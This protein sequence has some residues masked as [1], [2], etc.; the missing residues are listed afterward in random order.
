MR[1]LVVLLLLLCL[2][3]SLGSA[4]DTVRV[5]LVHGSFGNFRHRDDYDA[6]LKSLGWTLDKFENKDFGKLAA[7]LGNYDLV[8][9]T[10]LFNYSQNVTDFSLYREQLLS[11]VQRG[12]AVVLTDCN[13]PDHV[14]WLAKLGPDWAVGVNN[15]AT[16]GTPNK[17]FDRTHPLFSAVAPVGGLGGTWMH[18]E[19]AA[20]WQVLAR[21]DDDGA[22]ALLR[23]YGRG[24]VLL[25]SFWGYDPG[26]LRNI[27]ATLQYTRAG[28]LP[29]LPALTA[30]RLGD[31]A[32]A[33][34]FRNVTDQ[35]L[36]VQATATAT[37][38][39]GALRPVVSEATAAAGAE[40][41][42]PLT[43]PLPARGTYQVRLALGVKGGPE[44]P[45]AAAELTIPPLMAF[46]VLEPRYRGV[47][48]A[49]A[50]PRRVKAEVTLHPYAEKLEGL[51]W[52]ARLLRGTTL[53]GATAGGP[54]RLEPASGVG[55]VEFSLPYK[56]GQGDCVLELALAQKAGGKALYTARH[57]IAVV[58]E[59][60]AQ[61]FLDD[62]L[63]LRRDG[64][65]FFPI[66]VY[67]V[68]LKDFAQ[69]KA[70]GFNTIQA[71]GTK[72]AQ[73]RENLDAAQQAGLQVILEGV[74]YAANTGNLEAMLPVLKSFEKHPA[75]LSWYLTDEPSGAEKL[76][77]C[78]RVYKYLQ[79]VD[80]HH[81]VFMTSCSPTEFK[82]YAPVT[83][84]FAVDPYPIPSG[85]VTTVS[86]WM[87]MAREAT[88]GERP[89][90]LIPQLLNWAAYDGHPEKGRYPT[91][92][93]ER[94]MVYQGLVWGAKAIFYYPWD[95]GSTGLVK[96]A[97]LREA[98]GRINAELAE[99]GPRLLQC[100]YRLLARNE[101]EHKGLYAAAY[102]GEAETYIIAVN[103]GNQQAAL[104]VP[105]PEAPGAG[106]TVL[107]EGGRQVAVTAGAI[108][109][110]FAP[111]A[112]HVY[113]LAN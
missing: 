109:D 4:A 38:P 87:E 23:S 62:D 50:P 63:N 107:F 40:G 54:L 101:G 60:S 22:T 14:N 94:N 51:L 26:Q 61:V 35:P 85:P 32:L 102:R 78:D 83:D 27:V 68:P 77:W 45:A 33:V 75:L 110:T 73:A 7:Q 47:V 67:H 15:C 44:F 2:L 104:T 5:A 112:V 21:C 84:I 93:E 48:M 90:W 79:A 111:L 1:R 8:L 64:K 53:L 30:L 39:A 82:R 103:P 24:F 57:T 95:D 6:T 89:V 3:P 70:L 80:P 20:G 71:W 91:P 19:P 12:G 58:P 108:R 81:P 113:R 16:T 29:R 34:T 25:T 65:L 97:T 76:A 99:L 11:F 46:R 98:V 69:V 86:K 88:H 10:A 96:D 13:Y 55:R 92:D 100:R 74:T 31:N 59:R 28:V 49:A 106:A 41:V 9:G 36:T 42:L 17:W 52:T 37:G 56:A 18:M 66:A 72:P 105:V 43:L